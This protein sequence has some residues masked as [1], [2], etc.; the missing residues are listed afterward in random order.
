MIIEVKIIVGMIYGS[1]IFYKV[2]EDENSSINL[3]IPKDKLDVTTLKILDD[4]AKT[5][6][7]TKTTNSFILNEK[8][9]KDLDNLTIG[10][11]IIGIFKR[12]VN[13]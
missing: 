7:I 5:S 9:I 10:N 3:K 13:L 2:I 12:E 1:I 4:K 11:L 8:K 6:K